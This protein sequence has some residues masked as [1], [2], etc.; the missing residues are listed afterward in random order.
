[1]FQNPPPSNP[2]A[3]SENPGHIPGYPAYHPI[4]M[5]QAVGAENPQSELHKKGAELM[6]VYSNPRAV[7][8]DTRIGNMQADC[9]ICMVIT[10]VFIFVVSLLMLVAELAST[11]N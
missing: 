8:F 3:F 11:A 10:F 7:A 9:V 2:Y 4:P 1:M 6:D 5:A